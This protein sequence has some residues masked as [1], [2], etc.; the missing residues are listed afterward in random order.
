MC[1]VVCVH[2][3]LCRVARVPL[4]FPQ[5]EV[6]L[7][8]EVNRRMRIGLCSCNLWHMVV[9]KQIELVLFHILCFQ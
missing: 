3:C 4:W 6:N 7:G 1:E 8:C 2:F 9:P 5:V